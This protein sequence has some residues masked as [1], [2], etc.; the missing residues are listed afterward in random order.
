MI[1]VNPDDLFSTPGHPSSVATISADGRL[2]SISGQVSRDASGNTVGTGDPV[3]QARQIF[4]N[5]DAVLKAAGASPSDVLHLTVYVTRRD[6]LAAIVPVRQDYFR[7]PP[8][9][10]STAVVVS[11]LGKDEWLIEIQA[12]A[13]LPQRG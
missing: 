10:A 6:Y 5:L 3:A 11:G 12:T 9:P 8:Y 13:C 7:E 4:R 2:L 1:A